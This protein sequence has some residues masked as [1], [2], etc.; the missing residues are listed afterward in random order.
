MNEVS[1]AKVPIIDIQRHC[2]ADPCA[3]A[4]PLAHWTSAS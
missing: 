4:G 2:V 3:G 1:A